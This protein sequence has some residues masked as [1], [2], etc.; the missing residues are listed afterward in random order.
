MGTVDSMRN[1]TYTYVDFLYLHNMFFEIEFYNRCI[2]K[3]PENG[4]GL[5]FKM[6]EQEIN[7]QIGKLPPK[8]GDSSLNRESLSH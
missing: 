4:G 8:P 5:N 7:F 1:F 3:F 6:G 2:K